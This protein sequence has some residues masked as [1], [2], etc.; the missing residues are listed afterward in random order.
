M[1][2]GGRRWRIVSSAKDLDEARLGY[3]GQYK[4]F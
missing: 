1:E 2:R 3:V 4:Y